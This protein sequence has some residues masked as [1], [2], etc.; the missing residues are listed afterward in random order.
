[1]SNAERS[2]PFTHR[3]VNAPPHDKLL[4]GDL[5]RKLFVVIFGTNTPQGRAFDLALL[6][7][8]VCSV[9]AV[10]LETVAEVETAWRQGL[11]L[12]EWG[13]T[14]VFTIEYAVRLYCVPNRLRYARSF[15]GLVDLLSILPTYLSVLVTGLQ[16]LLV[17]R[18]LRLLRVFRVLKVMRLMSE[19][20]TLMQA[21]R[22]SVPKIGV[23]VGGV[24]TIV[25]ITGA[26]MFLIEGP[27]HGFT[28]I[29]KSMYWAI[30][31]LTTVGYG[32]I[33]PQTDLGQTL[34]SLLM[35]M[36]YGIIAVPTGIV[37]SE[38]VQATRGDSFKRCESCKTRVHAADALFC[39]ICGSELL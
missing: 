20:T 14:I 28:S 7:V 23:F 15:F 4:E 2:P 6:I 5:R 35:I 37:S 11:R 12:A 3:K 16:S 17:I 34:A 18:V 33:S 22:A 9:L 1:M 32:D 10:M 39:R 21:L 36:G 13:F 31:T 26:I 8:I 38:L 27:Q 30:V 29:P 19:A 25:V 24:L